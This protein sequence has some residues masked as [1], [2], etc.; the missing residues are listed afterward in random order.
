MIVLRPRQDKFISD[1]REAFAEGHQRVLAVAPTSFGKT[2]CFSYIA[3]NA[4]SLGNRV[5]ICVHRRELIRQTARSMRDDGI[6]FGVI[7]AGYPEL[8]YPIQLCSIQTLVRRLPRYRVPDLIIWDESHRIIGAVADA[9]LEWGANAHLLGVTATPIRLDGRGFDHIFSKMVLGPDV[10]T[11]IQDNIDKPGTGLSKPVLYAPPIE[12]IDVSGVK[13]DSNGELNQVQLG[14]TMHKREI[15]GS[16]VEH[17]Q[18][19]LPHH[20]PTVAFCAGIK[21]AELMAAEFKKNDI[22]SE[23]IDGSMDDWTR[24]Q[25]IERLKNGTTKVLTSCDL[26]SEGFDLPA[27]QCAILLRPTKSLAL[28]IQQCGRAIRPAP[29]KVETIILDHVNNWRVHGLIEEKREWTLEGRKKKRTAPKADTLTTCPACFR[30][31]PPADSCPACGHVLRGAGGGGG[32]EIKEVDGELVRIDP[33]ALIQPV[34]EMPK[35]GRRGIVVR[36]LE[37]A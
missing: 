9:I 8:N 27:I 19:L 1:I 23:S 22:A 20:P 6:K 13:T 25:I 32:R 5:F 16:A 21:N 29:G 18:R 12:S 7:A 24:E 28:Y 35:K 17:Y 34:V 31:F 33:A 10:P 26:I 2:K 14:E 11:L 4:A 15:Y 36:R 37:R 30:C 3:Q